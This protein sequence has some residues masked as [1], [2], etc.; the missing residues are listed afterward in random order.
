MLVK[1]T[2]PADRDRAQR[3]VRSITVASAAA[4]GALTLVGVAVT[5]ASFG[6]RTVGA[7]T[8]PAQATPTPDS[9]GGLQQPTQ[10][11][12]DGSDTSSSSTGSVP[13]VSGGS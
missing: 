8:Q 9:S 5:S 2:S 7:S 11:P 4:A 13:I 6:G 1:Q 10:V 3:R 12:S